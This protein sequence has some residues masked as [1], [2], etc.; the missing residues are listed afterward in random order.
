MRG[1]SRMTSYADPG[2][3]ADDTT[4]DYDGRRV[5]KANVRDSLD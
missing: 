4:Y 1:E 3:A 2:M 5:K